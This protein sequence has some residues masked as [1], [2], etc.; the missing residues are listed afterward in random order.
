MFGIPQIITVDHGITFNGN[1]KDEFIKEYGI[2]LI[3]STPYY[4][5]ANGQAE[6]TNKAIKFIIQKKIISEIPRD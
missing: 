1:L 6:A 3:N 4:A 5:Q 2:L